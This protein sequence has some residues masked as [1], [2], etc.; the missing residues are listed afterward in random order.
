MK[1]TILLASCLVNSAFAAPTDPME[2]YQL[3][4][5]TSEQYEMISE[6]FRDDFKHNNP[7]Q[8]AHVTAFE[9]FRDYQVRSG[10]VFIH[11]T[12]K[13]NRVLDNALDLDSK[14]KLSQK[15]TYFFLNG[16][17]YGLNEQEFNLV[18]KNIPWNYHVAPYFLI[19]GEEIVADLHVQL[20][21]ELSSNYTIDEASKTEFG[22]R[23]IDQWVE[24]LTVRG[25]LLWGI[26]KKY[27][28]AKVQEISAALGETISVRRNNELVAELSETQNRINE[29]DMNGTEE[30]IDIKC[31]EAKSMAEVDAGQETEWCFYSRAPMNYYNQI[32]LREI[33]Y[34]HLPAKEGAR[35]NQSV[36]TKFHTEENF[37][38]GET[39]KTTQKRG[40]EKAEVESAYKETKNGM[41]Y[42]TEYIGNEF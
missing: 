7:Y 10:K 23:S 2:G 9:A 6:N 30:R 39:F 41:P 14:S 4:N 21:K 35:Y 16:E 22:E 5:L 26:K 27:L 36:P 8:G 15:L 20:P 11:Y 13:W 33:A 12:Q 3:T 1:K 31:K 32:D 25:E 38:A 24:G 29:L 28:L 37:R 34:G 42:K 17:D 19:N 18:K 40:F